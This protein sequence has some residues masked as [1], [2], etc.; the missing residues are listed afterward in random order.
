M[1]PARQPT[2]TCLS[3]SAARL[4][5][6]SDGG[7]RDA[8][9]G[10]PVESDPR[11]ARPAGARPV[12]SSGSTRV[13]QPLVRRIARACAREKSAP[14]ASICSIDPEVM[15]QNCWRGTP[16]RS[17]FRPAASTTSPCSPTRTWPRC[18]RVGVVGRRDEA[19]S[20]ATIPSGSTGATLGTLP[21]D[22]AAGNPVG[23]RTRATATA[24]ATHA[25]IA[26]AAAGLPAVGC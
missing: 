19:G 17:R 24:R 25:T 16:S 13:G 23:T 6:P 3:R 8:R 15:R 10:D 22:A 4:Q 26:A 7:D 18:W 14:L 11:R 5:W 2:G 1:P 21:Q 12:S 20:R 9:S